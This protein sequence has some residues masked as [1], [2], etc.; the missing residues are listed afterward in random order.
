MNERKSA[1]TD[2]FK[3][4][5]L[6]FFVIMWFGRQITFA[7]VAV[8]IVIFIEDSVNVTYKLTRNFLIK[9]S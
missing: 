7:S 4:Q 9:Q 8:F 6:T 1:V 5:A 3:S 2:T